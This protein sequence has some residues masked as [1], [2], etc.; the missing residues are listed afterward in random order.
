VWVCGLSSVE[1]K[2]YKMMIQ[3]QDQLLHI[4]GKSYL[5]TFDRH[6]I[7]NLWATMSLQLAPQTVMGRQEVY[8]NFIYYVQLSICFQ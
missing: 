6:A 8:K 2:D 5:G 4:K 1:N 3:G 7:L